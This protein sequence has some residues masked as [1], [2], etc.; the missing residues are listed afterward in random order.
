MERFS[1]IPIVILQPEPLGPNMCAP[2]GDNRIHPLLARVDAK[3][4][5]MGRLSYVES[6]GQMNNPQ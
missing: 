1:P 2:V 3:L 6:Y 5:D 4:Q